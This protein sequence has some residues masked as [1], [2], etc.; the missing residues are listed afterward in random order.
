MRCQPHPSLDALSSCWRWALLVPSPYSW[1]LHLRSLALG[2]ESLSPPRSRCI[3]EGPPTSYLPISIL[4]AGHQKAITSG[5]GGTWEE[6]LM[7]EGSGVGRGEP[8][9][10]LDEGR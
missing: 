1:A 6:K 9:Q 2:P 7:E 4:S 5:E 3:L 8:D 10:V